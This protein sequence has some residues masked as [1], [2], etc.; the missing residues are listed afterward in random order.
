MK[1][2]SWDH[3]LIKITSRSFWA[4][5]AGFVAGIMALYQF[6]D[7]VTVQIS[8]LIVSFGSIVAYLFTNTNDSDSSGDD[9]N[10]TDK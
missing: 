5:M 6:S 10:G 9:S 7:N 1:K 3:F 8:G 2:F 4:M